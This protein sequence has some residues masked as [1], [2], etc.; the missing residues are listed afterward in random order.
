M[1][2]SH[3]VASKARQS[4]IPSILVYSYI[5]PTHSQVNPRPVTCLLGDLVEA[6]GLSWVGGHELLLL[7]ICGAI[8]FSLSMCMRPTP[9]G[10]QYCCPH[11]PASNRT[12][13]R[14]HQVVI[15]GD[16]WN[17]LHRHRGDRLP[18]GMVL[19]N[20]CERGSRRLWGA[21]T[22][23]V[24]SDLPQTSLK[25]SSNLF[26]PNKSTRAPG[27]GPDS[28]TCHPNLSNQIPNSHPLT[29]HLFGQWL[30]A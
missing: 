21:Q 3:Q 4:C 17:L 14:G 30:E 24:G 6:K 12:R 29:N 8:G 11:A 22:Q 2:R 23:G 27:G 9:L 20:A 18:L 1:Y 28:G 10:R 13:Q 26:K 16:L 5:Q 7:L 25:N 19:A 15:D